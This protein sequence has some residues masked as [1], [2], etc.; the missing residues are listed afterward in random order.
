MI[1]SDMVF[2][3]SLNDD[4]LRLAISSLGS[5]SLQGEIIR[6]AVPAK[7][8]SFGNSISLS[9]DL[10]AINADPDGVDRAGKADFLFKVDK[11]D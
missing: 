5:I 2:S 9:G 1:S 4:C 7:G 3:R 8:D 10:L 6:F 11:S